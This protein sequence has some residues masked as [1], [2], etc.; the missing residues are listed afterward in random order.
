MGKHRPTY[1]PHIDTGDYVI[2]TNVDKVVFTGNKWR[3]KF[4]QRY[5]GYPGGQKDEAAWKLFERRPERILRAGDPADD[6]QEQ[7]RP[8]H[9]GQAQA[10]RRAEPSPPGPV[11]DPARG[12]VGTSHARRVRSS[13]LHRRQGRTES[14]LPKPPQPAPAADAGRAARVR[15]RARP[16]RARLEHCMPVENKRTGRHESLDRVRR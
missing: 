2:V 12:A 9:D 8:S 4:Y 14:E 15:R 6:A 3:Q 1:T 13:S 11:P 5:S 16:H 7:D 10:L